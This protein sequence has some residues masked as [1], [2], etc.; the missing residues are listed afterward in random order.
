MAK[1]KEKKKLTV[2]EIKEL[3]PKA[4][5]YELSPFRKYIIVVKKPSIVGIDPARSYQTAKELARI[6]VAMGISC[7]LLVNVDDDVKF[8]E[9]S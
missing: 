3:E 5:V 7:Q 1:P 4:E 6:L 9:I 2:K 8:L